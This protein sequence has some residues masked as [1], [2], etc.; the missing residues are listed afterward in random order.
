[1]NIFI[2]FPFQ[3]KSIRGVY[4]ASQMGESNSIHTVISYNRGATWD[5]IQRP[6]G[7]S[8]VDESKVMNFSFILSLII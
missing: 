5:N 6:Q 2:Y 4:L 3:V 8:C 7:S 1:M